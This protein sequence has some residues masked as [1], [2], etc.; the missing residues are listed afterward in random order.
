MQL[1]YSESAVQ[2]I[3]ASSS[4][5]TESSVAEY[6]ALQ[7]FVSNV[8]KRCLQVEDGGG[9]QALQL[10]SFLNTVRDKTWTDM[11]GVLSA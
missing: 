10:V 2:Q 3:R 4:F 6:Q 5:I 1:Y 7:D 8:S 9:P 11:K